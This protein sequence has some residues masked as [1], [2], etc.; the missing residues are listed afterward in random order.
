MFYY[1]QYRL[2][3]GFGNPYT[4]PPSSYQRGWFY[5]QNER[6][7]AGTAH[8]IVEIIEDDFEIDKHRQMVYLTE[9]YWDQNENAWRVVHAVDT[10]DSGAGWFTWLYVPARTTLRASCQ[11]KLAPNFGT[12]YP[13]FEARASQSTSFVNRVGNAD[14]SG[15]TNF[16]SWYSGGAVS[17]TYTALA[18]TQYE[19]RQLTLVPVNFPRHVIVGVRMNNRNQFRGFWMRDI[20]VFLDTPYLLPTY[21]YAHHDGGGGNFGIQANFDAR[22]LRLGGGRIKGN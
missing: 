22:R 12:N 5:T 15:D 6:S 7:P 17:N 16:R 4:E 10:E 14:S 3:S 21:K 9:R 1:S 11:I 19:E 2:C 18:S 8:T 13:V 20:N